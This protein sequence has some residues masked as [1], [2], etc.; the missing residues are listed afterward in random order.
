MPRKAKASM[1]GLDPHAAPQEVAP[2]STV[3][4]ETPRR[5]TRV[6]GG[7]K[8][9]LPAAVPSIPTKRGQ[10][11]TRGT[12]PARARGTPRGARVGG[13][14]RKQKWVAVPSPPSSISAP[15]DVDSNYAPQVDDAG[16]DEEETA[17]EVSDDHAPAD[18]EDDEGNHHEENEPMED[19]K[20]SQISDVVTAANRRNAQILL[21]LNVSV[22]IDPFAS[23]VVSQVSQQSSCPS[24][25]TKQPLRPNSVQPRLLAHSNTLQ[26]ASRSASVQP[27]SRAD[28]AQ[29]PSH[30]DNVPPSSRMDNVPPSRV[31][32][33]QPPSRADSVRPPSRADGV[34]PLSRA[35]GVQPLS[36]AHS[37]R[38]PSRVDGTWPPSRL[39]GVRPPSRAGSVR[40]P[41]HTGSTHLPSRAGS[42]QPSSHPSNSQHR[43]T[44]RG[45]PTCIVN[46]AP[47]SGH[48]RSFQPQS[49]SHASALRPTS[50][51]P[52]FSSY[53]EL[54]V[55]EAGDEGSSVTIGPELLN[56]QPDHLLGSYIG[57][58]KSALAMATRVFNA[59]I[60]AIN[61]FPGPLA[62]TWAS[63]IWEAQMEYASPRI[64]LTT[65]MTTYITGQQS[66]FR[67]RDKIS[68]EKD[69]K[70]AY[71]LSGGDLLDKVA[72]ILDGNV[73]IYSSWCPRE[74]PNR[75][76]KYTQ[77]RGVG[78]SY[79]HPAIMVVIKQLA[80]ARS[81]NPEHPHP[82]VCDLV[83]D[84][85]LAE[86]SETKVVPLALYAF[87]VT[88]IHF[89]LDN[90]KA[91][92]EDAAAAAA[93]NLTVKR[94]RADFGTYRATYQR[95]LAHAKKH[96]E[97]TDNPQKLAKMY[98]LRR[99]H[100]DELSREYGLGV[101]ACGFDRDE[102]ALSTDDEASYLLLRELP[103]AL[104][105]PEIL[106]S[107]VLHALPEA[108]VILRDDENG[109]SLPLSSISYSADA[110]TCVCGKPDLVQAV[111][112]CIQSTC[113]DEA[114]G[115]ATMCST[116]SVSTSG[117][118]TAT[119][120]T[121]TGSGAS[122]ATV[123][124]STISTGA[125]ATATSSAGEAVTSSAST[126]PT[127]AAVSVR[128][129]G[130]VAGAAV[131]VAALVF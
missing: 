59:R 92:A 83:P 120:T 48:S 50:P 44:T 16:E 76:L 95:W 18:T 64:K 128:A 7:S 47:P 91:A 12:F 61:A 62:T 57:S 63:E 101:T 60:L 89:A 9:A 56:G 88:Q 8:K 96:F 86:D 103:E 38:P 126:T 130:A 74:A 114:A 81:G 104:E 117:S 100:W 123:S 93:S 113:P 10:P 71:N 75:L 112:T 106:E 11:S 3:V 85:F 25:G 111:S 33:V 1:P 15:S 72:M 54:E 23:T 109:G 125:A 35:D 58:T 87:A 124:G 42:M 70:A 22:Q 39:D 53:E 26:L 27:P 80:F 115:L 37:V 84:A 65:G 45:Q 116:G 119:G 5:S 40:P 43:G 102:E 13:T 105:S 98:E 82:F 68:I 90:I 127:G 73:F 69:V 31:D 14:S 129:G 77:Q 78:R 51:A 107:P 28:S 52:E 110:I 121:A 46:L 118:V 55:E 21:W 79:K 97:P 30:L 49:T 67:T 41:S 131:M 94:P 20:L 34:R 2:V 17:E 4:T 66:S 99:E 36:R 6:P 24:N 32:G 19:R 122:S 108:R 29:P